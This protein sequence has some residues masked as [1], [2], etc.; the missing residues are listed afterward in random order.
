VAALVIAGFAAG[1]GTFVAPLRAFA[2]PPV[3][4]SA[5]VG[6]S[7]P[8]KASAPG[9]G[10]AP[11]LGEPRGVAEATALGEA[12]GL[13]EAPAESSPKY[14]TPENYRKISYSGLPKEKGCGFDLTA[15]MSGLK[16]AMVADKLRV[17]QKYQ[18]VSPL[19]ITKVKEFQRG[20]QLPATG[21]VDLRTWLTL[22]FPEYS[23]TDFDCYQHKL[24]VTKTMSREQIVEAFVN[25]ALE[26]Q[27]SKY[28]WGGANSPSQ[29]ADCSG[30][31]IQML[32]AVG[33]NPAPYTVVGHSL[34]NGP[35]T[36]RIYA[37][38]SFKH[39]PIAQVARGDLVFYADTGG[40]ITHVGVYLGNNKIM[41]LVAGGGRI[42][43]LRYRTGL[44]AEAV[45][46]IP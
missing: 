10:K 36:R 1:V 2:G 23:W 14:Q 13:G 45:R 34:P 15:G 32:Y 12:H 9:T 33:I 46:P 24:V 26:Y 16:T 31:V 38:P 44:V 21:T 4:A 41:E 20:H 7:T 3:K 28:I 22:G 30:L 35:T 29:G 40:K 18:T 19:F 8:I 5:H 6:A 25:V 27:G 43:N 11:G 39:V 37:D 17:A 42:A